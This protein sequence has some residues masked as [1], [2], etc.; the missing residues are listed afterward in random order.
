VT[1]TYGPEVRRRVM[2]RIKGRD[3]Q[4][5]LLLRRSLHALGLRGWRCH[6]VTLPGK[7]DLAFGRAR[8]AVFVDG[9]FWHG[10]PSRYWQGRTSSYWDAK[11]SRN[12]AR[13]KRVN[14]MLRRSGWRV[15]RVWDFQ[16][17]AD[18]D[19]AARRVAARLRVATSVDALMR[20]PSA[21]PPS[22]SPERRAHH[23]SNESAAR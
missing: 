23:A 17:T 14:S 12:Q 9:A 16:I 8:V 22:R 1:D 18:P 11:I 5:E 21:M 4:P 19:R 3:T 13:D 7:P 2:Q 20:A 6:R 15:M 10:H